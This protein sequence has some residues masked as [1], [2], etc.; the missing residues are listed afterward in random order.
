M[1]GTM[2]HEGFRA[3]ETLPGIYRHAEWDVTVSCHG[4]DFLAEGCTDGLDRLDAVMTKGFE[5]KI[6]PRIGARESGGMVTSASPHQ[7]GSG[8]VSLAGRSKYAQQLFADLGLTG[9]KG[10]DS[11]ATGQDTVRLWD[12]RVSQV[13]LVLVTGLPDDSVCNGWN[14]SRNGQAN[15]ANSVPS[16]AVETTWATPGKVSGGRVD[17]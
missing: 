2:V 12:K 7:V 5:V 9:T 14:R 6:L 13:L 11:P 3:V 16:T 10:V 17:L 1:T 8:R 15:S 4:D